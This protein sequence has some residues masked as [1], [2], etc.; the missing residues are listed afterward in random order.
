M[1]FS[2]LVLPGKCEMGSRTDQEKEFILYV[3]SNKSLSKRIHF[4]CSVWHSTLKG[5]DPRIIY[6]LG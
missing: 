2:F 5:S 1:L 4:L 6:K 3:Y